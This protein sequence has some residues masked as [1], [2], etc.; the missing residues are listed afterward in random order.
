M[1][2]NVTLVQL[3]CFRAVIEQGGFTTAANHLCL[4]QSAVSQ[5]VSQLEK[6]IG[7]PLV[8]RD[9][10]GVMPTSAGKVVLDEARI[11]L[12]AIERMVVSTTSTLTLTGVLNVGVVQ[13]AAVNLLPKWIRQLRTEHPRVTVKLFEG[14]DPEVMDWMLAGVVDVGI[15]SRVHSDLSSLPVYQDDYLIVLP[16]DHRLAKRPYL[17][18]EALNGE[19]M[20]L[21]GGGCE[22][23]IEELLAASGSAPDIICLVRDNTTLVSMVRAGVGLT[24]MPELALMNDRT[25]IVVVELRPALPRTLYCLTRAPGDHPPILQ[26]FVSHVQRG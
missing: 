7:N 25:G 4:S 13:S 18:L 24:I 1:F 3:R 14:T 23:L 6:T 2:P 5:A 20:L 15:T 12:A 11:A 26:A 17:G 10:E 21:S 22:T 9:R 8:V 16:S 19:R